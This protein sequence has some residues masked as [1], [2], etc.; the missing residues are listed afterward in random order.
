M[1]RSQIL[2]LPGILRIA[3]A[4]ALIGAAAP[5]VSSQIANVP[6]DLSLTNSVIMPYRTFD[7]LKFTPDGRLSMIYWTVTDSLINL[8]FNEIGS[9]GQWLPATVTSADNE[10]PAPLP[11]YGEDIASN[12]AQSDF[13]PPAALLYDSLG[14]PHIV[15]ENISPLFGPETLIH[16]ARAPSGWEDLGE[17]EIQSANADDCFAAVMGPGDII[18]VVAGGDANGPP[19]IGGPFASYIY[20]P[21]HY[22]CVGGAW[23]DETSAEGAMETVSPGDYTVQLD[24][25]PRAFSM[26]VDSRGFLHVAY[27]PEDVDTGNADGSASS[28]SQLARMSNESGQW[29]SETVYDPPD[30]HSD[31]GLGASIAIA[32]NGQPAI[33]SF[34]DPRVQT[35]SSAGGS[36]LF[37]QRGTNGAWTTT[38]VANSASGY[39]AGDGN[40]GTGFAPSLF[41]DF[42]GRP[43]IVFTDHASQHFDGQQDEF[44]GN[45]RHAWLYG[46]TW[47]IQ[48]LFQQSDPVHNQVFFPNA[49]SS[50]RQ[51]AAMGTVSQ[52]QL[53][54]NLTITN[55]LFYL[56]LTGF[57][58]A[59][60][61]DTAP[62]AATITSPKAN[63][64]LPSPVLAVAGAASDNI[65]VLG[66]F[67]RLNSYGWILADTTNGWT[68]WTATFSLEPGSNT[69][70]AYAEDASGNQSATNT[71]AFAFNPES[72]FVVAQPAGATNLAGS[73]VVLNV[74]AAGSGPLNFQW[75]MNGA[76]LADGPSV[77]GVE[78]TNL[79]LEAVSLTNTAAYDVVISNTFGVVTS[80]VATL[81]VLPPPQ[82]TLARLAGISLLLSGNGGYA[83]QSYELLTATNLTQPLADWTP[84]STNVLAADGS[85]SVTIS[86]AVE[87][88]VPQRYYALRWQ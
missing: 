28:Y 17:I 64:N 23:Q 14:N 30:G 58:P 78:S 36:L 41:F 33:A 61:L 52:D 51:L 27:T 49:A 86:A 34:L 22:T 79:V 37:H 54:E 88:T 13:A 45:L 5:R 3:A 59:N 87:S 1:N 6:P 39:T 47:R 74:A 12:P 66:V 70:Q 21:V 8:V 60:Y 67:C 40:T 19:N 2:S 29:K 81:L 55:T 24:Y 80:A 25:E 26:A 69:V 75:R 56:N 9:D 35:G 83:G 62:P 11:P 77:S 15:L 85:F 42:A 84:V 31:A 32:P 73:T 68:N 57:L 4:A 50:P 71:V 82:I 18:H 7:A 72:P 44:C 16:F 10:T 43:H 46:G 53:D 20:T 65:G 38:I 48:T 63:Q 76:S